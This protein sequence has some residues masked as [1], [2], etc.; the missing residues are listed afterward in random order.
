MRRFTGR[1][2]YWG[3]CPCWLSQSTVSC[4]ALSCIP[5]AWRRSFRPANCRPTM[6]RVCSALRGWKTTI[7]SMRLMNSG[8]RKAASAAW[9][10]VASASDAAASSTAILWSR[11]DANRSPRASAPALDV[12][13]IRVLRKSTSRPLLSVRRPSSR[14]WSRMLNTSGWAFSISSRSTTLYGRRRTAS[15]SCPP[16]S[17][18]M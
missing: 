9:A 14:T 4:V 1:A 10:S 8:R 3:S 2:P 12:M 6:A 7:S 18:P 5:A 16:S 11:A 17:W 15:V 13:M